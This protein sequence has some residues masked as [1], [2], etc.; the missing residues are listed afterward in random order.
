[1]KRSHVALRYAIAPVAV[2][3]ALAVRLSLQ[4]LLLTEAE[5][6][7]FLLAVFCTTLLGGMGPGIVAAVL[8]VLALLYYLTPPAPL[9]SVDSS[10]HALALALFCA[11]SAF[12]IVM[13]ES[14]RRARFRAEASA[15]LAEKRG[16]DL[17]KQVDRRQAAELAERT[18]REWLQVTLASIGDGVIVT[19]G[20]GW[21]V[22]MNAAAA[23]LTKWTQAEAA[24][25][26]VETVFSI[27]NEETD[28]RVEIPVAR[29]IRE[30]R[31]VGLAN[32]TILIAK[33]G[34][35]IPID[36]SG[37]PIV[38]SSGSV[39]GAVLV[40]RDVTEQKA[41]EAELWRLDRMV[42][43]SHDAVIVA[44]AGRHIQGWNRGAEEIYGWTAAEALG[45]AI[46]ELL[47]TRSCGEA[48]EI[49]KVLAEQGRWEG[50]LIQTCKDGTEVVSES[51]H[52]L[53]RDASGEIT[54]ILE[55][56][57][58]ITDRKRAE[59]ALRVS[60]ERLA[61]AIESADL[62][63]WYSDIPLGHVVWNDTCKRHFGL[64]PDAEV[65]AE[66]A[67]E[68]VHPDDRERIQLAI[69]DAIAGRS[70]FD[71]ECR[72]VGRDGVTRWIRAAGRAFPDATGKPIRFD[73]VTIEITDQKRR[74][75]AEREVQRLESLGLLAGGIA[76][77][78]NNLLTGVLGNASLILE[79]ISEAAPERRCLEAIVHA[80][81]RAAQ[82]THQI[83]AY[84]G[85][86]RFVIQP[87]DMSRFIPETTALI[88][89]S[90]PKSVE[91]RLELATDLPAVQA[92]LAQLQ[93]LVMNLVVNGAE[94]V[95]P[96]GGRVTVRTRTESIGADH[97]L[98]TRADQPLLPG[99]YVLL[100][101]L[102]TGCGMDEA[103]L[104]R[105]FDPFF[106][107][108]FTG[109]G[110]GLSAV[111]GIVRG[112]HG[113][114]EVVTEPKQG[115]AFRV[116]LPA[117]DGAALARSGQADS[118]RGPS[119]PHRGAGAVLVVDDEEVVRTTV[120]STLD[121]L[122][123]RTFVARDGNEA[124]RIL[125]TESRDI[126]LVLLDMT[127]PGIS[128][129]ETLQRLRTVCPA[130]PILLSSGFSENE[131]LR[132]FGS[133][134]LAGFLQ[135]PYTAQALAQKVARAAAGK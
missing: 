4:P 57:R 105:I 10:D 47:N 9:W 88:Q 119:A 28:T 84:A 85:R 120:Q 15:D 90:I 106:T 97:P 38:D 5:Y 27:R 36:D 104:A 21:V 49:G 52:L 129:E 131:A 128:G 83:L 125:Q 101:V 6:T 26:R 30:G 123:Y 18:Q 20:E 48:S 122:G 65:T 115:S 61:L 50:E 33:D 68:L 108:K 42:N 76:H 63:L 102:D 124:V 23:R 69:E 132:R 135:K 114:I 72:T 53:L 13:A 110:L 59:E 92:D 103:T 78:F 40:F 56:N 43:A 117:S 130:V 11:A 81:E 82:L 126:R 55:I 109:R 133:C 127:M 2:G 31:V 22:L 29:A 79:D 96:G 46:H 32:R 99:R 62:G 75:E 67:S 7:T 51:R 95:G 112:H 80:A 3:A 100:E 71:V 111:Q 37:A 121:R 91:L 64:P 54:G 45:K 70:R 107:T 35:R 98:A 60:S 17:E 86:G 134:D 1:M 25:Q 118:E 74:E 39:L 93:Q 34:A 16:R 89:A 58:D 19:D 77:D 113:A 94:A 66:L 73:G 41:R 116:L 87:V 14:Q 24:G 44:D 12:S 8:S